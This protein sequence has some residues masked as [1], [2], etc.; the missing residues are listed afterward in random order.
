[1]NFTNCYEDT[2]RAESY[3]KLE[4]PGTYYLAYRDL[5]E[6]ILKHT[7]IGKAIDFGCG[8]G[9]STRFLKKLG[10]DPTGIDISQNML[11]LAKGIDPYGKYLL[12]N[13]GNYSHLGLGEYE[14]VQSIFTF[15]NISGWEN[16]TKILAG[17]R[18]LLKPSG[19]IVCLDSSH[20]LYTN[21]W[22][23]FTTRDFYE[24]WNAKTG[25]IVRDIILDIEDKSPVEDIYWTDRDYEKL[26]ALAGLKI[27]ATYRPM[28][29]E[30][31]SINW[32]SEKRIAPWVIYVLVKS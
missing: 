19:R 10:F 11:N 17:L 6:I 27:E 7:E 24:N 22:V 5:P 1:M 16:R 9:R 12:V 21:E 32:L 31:E 23:S 29:Y 18:D 2:K 28:G 3:A 14:L 30:G 20:E 4:F 26:F 15:D 25:D 13:D 8:T